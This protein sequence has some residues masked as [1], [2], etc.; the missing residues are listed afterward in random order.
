MY[1]TVFFILKKD[2]CTCFWQMLI[3]EQSVSIDWL[4]WSTAV[5]KTLKY[6]IFKCTIEQKQIFYHFLQVN[7]LH[8]F[9]FQPNLT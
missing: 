4:T 9:C 3:A 1:Q 7:I 6:N 8:H 2:C 5:K